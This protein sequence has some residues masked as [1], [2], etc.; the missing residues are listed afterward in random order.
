VKH[1]AGKARVGDEQI[2]AAAEDEHW[3]VLPAGPCDGFRDVVFAG[4]LRKP[5]CRATD[6]KGGEGRKQLVFFHE[7]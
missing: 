2:A 6:A 1:K 4:G 5:A 7:H 3:H